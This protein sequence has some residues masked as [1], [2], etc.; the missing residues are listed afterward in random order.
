[1]EI[2]EIQTINKSIVKETRKRLVGFDNYIE[3]IVMCLYADGHV[4]LEGNPGIAKTLAASTIAE[5]LGM[6][7]GRIQF[8]PDLMPSDITGVN[9]FNQKSLEFEYIEGPVFNNFLLCD[10]INRSPPKTQAALLEAMQE[11]QVSVEG[12]ARSLPSPFIA[13][14]TQN[15]L[16]HQGTYNLPEAQIDRFLMKII[17]ELP[18]ADV[19]KTMLRLKDE[20]LHP[21]VDKLL[22]AS[23]ILDMQQSI[24]SKIEISDQI[25]EYIINIVHGTRD[26]VNI[27]IP[28]S[29]RASIA[30]MQLGKASAAM[31]GRD[32]VQPDDI[33]NI[34]FSVL[35]HRVGLSHE[36]ELDRITISEVIN[37]LLTDVEV[38]I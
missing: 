28:A 15:P 37:K 26:N 34:A 17:M 22:S 32:Y 1:M 25:L 29:P 18:S 5:I 8:T 16:E 3:N 6:E 13:I 11:R 30:L 12:I 35:N 33:K 4:L 31:N 9:V 14:A 21:S 7:F 19:E 10:E 27:D 24:S 23:I 36:A 2:E 38:S 20:D